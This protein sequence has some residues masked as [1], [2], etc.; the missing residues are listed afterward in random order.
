MTVPDTAALAL[1]DAAKGQ[2][3]WAIQRWRTS[4]MTDR[5]LADA[6]LH[7]PAMSDC[8][9]AALPSASSPADTGTIANGGAKLDGV[10]VD[11]AMVRRAMNAFLEESGGVTPDH[12][13]MRAALVA[14]LTPAPPT[15]PEPRAGGPTS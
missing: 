3:F 10:T 4:R 13:A 8:F 1:I 15:E 6:I 2:T 9:F 14:A 11:D 5:E 12:Q 7:S